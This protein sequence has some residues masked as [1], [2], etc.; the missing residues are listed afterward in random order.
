MERDLLRQ[1]LGFHGP[2]LLSLL[3]TEQHDNSDFR[4][5]LPPG[6]PSLELSREAQHQPPARKEKRIDNI[7]I[8]HFI[9]KK[10]DLLFALSWKP[11]VS[12]DSESNEE[13]EDCYA[14][15]PSL[16]QFMEV[17][18]EDRRE[19]FFRDIERGDVVIGRI[20]SIREF[21][22]FMVLICLGSGVV[23]E[24]SQLEITALCPLRD[25][26][27]HSSHGDPLSYYQTGDIIQ[28]AIKDID[29]YHEKLTISLHSSALPP[30]LS[31]TKLGVISS[32]DLPLHYR[33]GVEVAST[34]ETYEK[35]LHHSLGFANPSVVEFLLGKLGLSESSP[36]SLMRGLQSKNFNEEDF[37]FALRRKQSA[38]W[39]LKCVKIGVDYFKVGRHVEAM[40]EYNKAL[41]IDAQ[42]VEALVARGALYATTGSLNKA[43]DDFEVALK[44]CPTHRNARKYLCQTLVERGGQLEEEDNL[45]N[46]Q[47]YYKRALILDETFKEAE[48]ALL[49]LRKHMQKSLEMREK[50]AAKEERQKEKKIETSAQK[51]RKLLKEE[52]RLKKKRRRS[53]SSSSSSSSDSS[54]D[55]SV[56]SSSSSS[57]HKRHKKR[58]RNRSVS[59][60]SSKKHSSRVSS[61]QRDQSRKDEWY[62]PPADTS[63]SFLNQKYEMEKLLERQDRLVYQKTEVRERQCSL[64]RTSADEE[65]TFG[66]RSED[67]RD[68]YGS[69]KT[70]STSSKNEK[71][72]KA[73]RSFSNK[74][75]SSGSYHWKSDDKINTHD[76]RKLEKEVAGRKEQFRK[77]GSSQSMYSTSPA[78]SDYSGKSVEKNKQYSSTWL[79]EY[80]GSDDGSRRE[81]IQSTN[82]RREY[83]NRDRSHGKATEAKE[84]DEETTLNGKG[85]SESGVKKSLPQNLLNIFNQ[86]AEFE[87]QKGSKQK[88]Q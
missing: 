12:T 63:A 20:S 56:S 43:I 82:E 33:R 85:Q 78:E 32:E 65:D 29:R 53:T 18:S 42:N 62:S 51:L 49:K 9:A 47:N 30:S 4:G 35:V 60:R 72:G 3:R 41:E 71:Q 73:D 34:L 81:L 24:I 83:N 86:I 7:E 50:Q 84:L 66:G 36:P 23:R 75:G 74:R 31:S 25:V 38:S 64:S 40:N 5:L 22:F 88:N 46:A 26:P 15:M 8:Q 58:S 69:S 11:N 54:S 76:F 6:G 57:D 19:L 79:C 17:P 52:K 87:R 61:H 45:L 16:E 68:S 14:V 37:A 67:S 39:A 77:R 13:N 80:S 48:D 59:S 1:A 28:A 21:G 27:S 44:N 70:Q 55:V 10:A 2:A